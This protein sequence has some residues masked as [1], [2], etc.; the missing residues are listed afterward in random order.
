MTIYQS[1]NEPDG[2]PAP[3]TAAVPVPPEPPAQAVPP[4]SQPVPGAEPV[5][6]PPAVEPDRTLVDVNAVSARDEPPVERV[7]ESA[8]QVA[9][10]ARR[11]A[12]TVAADV[13]TQ[14]RRVV[15]DAKQSASERA[16]TQ[17]KQWSQRLGDVSR[18][19][20]EMASD[21]PQT[22][23]RTLVTQL[24]DRTA[25]LSDYLANR[26]AEDVLIQVQ[27]FAR[28]RPGAFLLAMAA[29]GFVAGRIG[30]GVATGPGRGDL[31]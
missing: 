17:Q 15:E 18:E 25:T 24:A 29:A 26:R 10:T 3:A 2:A 28:R 11:E 27:D 20:H 9:Q 23:A 1:D 21:R 19:L 7:K 13:R 5:T 12:N 6:A 30:K 8:A 4:E 16:D 14:V 22:P 31:R